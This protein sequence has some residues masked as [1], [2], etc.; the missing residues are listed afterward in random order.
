MIPNAVKAGHVRVSANML[1]RALRILDALFHAVEKQGYSVGWTSG[2]DATLHLLIDGEQIS[3]SITEIFARKPHTQTADE[4]A[5]KK[6]NLYVYLPKWDFIPT[7][8]LRLSIENL[9]WELSH[10]RK[11]WTDSERR[12]IENCLSEF[13]A[14]LP[15]LAKS[16]K[17]VRED[18]ERK[19]LQQEQEAKRA[20][21]NRRK[22]EEYQRRATVVEQFLTNWKQSNACR[23]FA[24]AMEQKK[25]SASATDDQ[26]Q[27]MSEISQWIVRHADNIDPLNH[28]DW[29]VKQFN[30]PPWKY[31]W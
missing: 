25:S 10:T 17:L 19:R 28:V 14:M 8:E 15:H 29:M 5:R 21:E 6:K 26:K 2:P 27:R 9:P 7:G 30:E 22:R 1:S 11:S 20:E 23:E 3:P 13:V 18:N 4:I 16:L 12:H 24:A 31:N